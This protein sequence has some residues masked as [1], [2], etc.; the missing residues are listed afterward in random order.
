MSERK[1]ISWGGA[2]DFRKASEFLHGRREGYKP[3]QKRGKDLKM[4]GSEWSRK[5]CERICTKLRRRCFLSLGVDETIL[6]K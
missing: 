5:V 2:G 6:A 3:Q 4:D 1:H